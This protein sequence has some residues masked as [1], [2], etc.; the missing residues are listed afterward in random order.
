MLTMAEVKGFS[1]SLVMVMLE[2]S[3]TNNCTQG[4]DDICGKIIGSISGFTYM[5]FSESG[6]CLMW[7]TYTAI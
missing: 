7:N 4:L 3:V 1:Y 5:N 2:K 6:C